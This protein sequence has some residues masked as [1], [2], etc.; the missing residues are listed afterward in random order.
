[1][2]RVSIIGATGYTGSELVKLLIRHP[3]VK[4][5]HCTSETYSGKPLG[6]V[7]S[8][9]NG[10]T[11][12]LLESFQIKSLF[13]DTDLAFLC[14]PH[15]GSAKAAAVLL[16]AG[17]KIV[18][19]S[20]DFRLI[21]KDTYAQW[22]GLKH[23]HPELLAKAVYGLPERYRAKISRAS[24]VAN[25]GCYATASILTARPLI[26]RGLIDPDSLVIDAK[27][28]VSGA[29]RKLETRYLYCE[30]NDN[31]LAY[32]VL[33]HRHLPEI[34][35]E[36]TRVKSNGGKVQVTFVPHLLPLTRGILTTV[37]GKMKKAV[38]PETLH[39]IYAEVYQNEPFVKVMELGSFPELRSVQ[40]SN[41]CH[42]GV[43]ADPRTKR[44]IAI[45][46]IDNLGKGASSQA[47]QN[48][49]I[50]YGWIE[51]AGLL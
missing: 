44:I 3:H 30:Q 25:P 38:Q 4:I 2:I 20:A 16:K 1:M 37:Y 11:D 13:R 10:R 40:N 35:Q 23:P 24:L 32:G 12:I 27:S 46:A 45:G 15:G 18:D 42:I 49:N 29:G 7:Q 21:S 6:Q 9:F 43:H 19:L 31:F 28:G 50:M 34:E 17:V 39:Q 51:S 5:A 36:L 8:W 14:L 47:V 22:Y 41:F 26:E 33:G 48:M